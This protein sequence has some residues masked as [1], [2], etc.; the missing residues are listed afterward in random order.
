MEFIKTESMHAKL[1][2]LVNKR[3]AKL[4]EKLPQE[5][6]ELFKKHNFLLLGEFFDYAKEYKGLCKQTKFTKIFIQKIEKQKEECP[7]EYKA[8]DF[9]D[10]KLLKGYYEHFLYI[11]SKHGLPMKFLGQYLYQ[12]FRLEKLERP[13]KETLDYLNEYKEY[14]V[15]NYKN[16]RNASK[17]YTS[18]SCISNRNVTIRERAR[19]LCRKTDFLENC[20]KLNISKNEAI[21]SMEKFIILFTERVSKDDLQDYFNAFDRLHVEKLSY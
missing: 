19:L 14:R 1:L 7:F 18:K 17:S 2:K 11:R 6:Q 9:Y 21:K 8:L 5:A 16:N 15:R 3:E 4:L 10:D 13:N 20:K 12:A